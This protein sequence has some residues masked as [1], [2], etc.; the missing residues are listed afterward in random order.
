MRTIQYAVNSE[1]HVYSRVGSEVVVPVL[2]YEKI[3]EGGDFNQ[4]L[5]YTLESFP[6]FALAGR[7]YNSLRWT[8]KIPL[9]IKNHH[10]QFWGMGLLKS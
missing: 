2:D 9:E 4:P 5:T 10:R 1:G 7:E 8:R 6:V 3:G